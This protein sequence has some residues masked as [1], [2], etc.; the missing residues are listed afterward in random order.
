MEGARAKAMVDE[1]TRP[2]PTPLSVT[3]YR[4]ITFPNDGVTFRAAADIG[5]KPWFDFG[6]IRVA[7][8][9][10]AEEDKHDPTAD[11]ADKSYRQLVKFWAFAEVDGQKY[12]L[13]DYF[14]KVPPNKKFK[15]RG[16]RQ[17]ESFWEH[18]VLK[19]YEHVPT[20]R[21]GRIVEP[22]FAVPVTSIIG[23]ACVFPCVDQ[24]RAAGDNS[25][26]LCVWYHPP[27]VELSGFETWK[28][29]S[30]REMFP[31]PS[32]SELVESDD[33]DNDDDGDGKFAVI[34]SSDE[35]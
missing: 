9:K 10:D 28:L 24:G 18:P 35:D 12:A 31:D 5:G 27:L 33:D 16:S 1:A 22:F 26:G 34:S 23:A 3:L 6:W 2:R 17:V 21:G 32:T 29:P 14:R 8:D 20:K 25:P 19:L 13:V 4:G 30:A 15:V 11:P 7:T